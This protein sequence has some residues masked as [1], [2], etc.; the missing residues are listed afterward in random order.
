M[1]EQ[2]ARSL[3]LLLRHWFALPCTVTGGT[4]SPSPSP[5]AQRNPHAQRQP[6]QQRQ[7]LQHGQHQRQP[8]RQRQPLP[9]PSAR[10]QRLSVRFRFTLN[11]ECVASCKYF[12]HKHIPHSFA[13]IYR[14]DK[15]EM[16]GIGC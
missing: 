8:Q 2:Q 9:P 14:K 4:P 6:Q 16:Q 15:W 13:H 11:I 3:T 1:R 12:L 7:G 10:S 5:H